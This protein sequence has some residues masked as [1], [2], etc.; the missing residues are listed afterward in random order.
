MKHLVFSGN[1][2]W[3]M[4]NFRG[5]LMRHFVEKGFKV[6]VTAPY[7]STFSPKLENLGCNFVDINIQAKGTNPFADF[8]LIV[9]Y[10]RLFKRLKPDMSITYTI[11]PNIYASIAARFLHIPFLPVTTGMGYVFLHNN[12]VCKIAKRL[13]RFAF[14]NAEKVWFLNG[15]DMSIFR[16]QKLIADDKIA[17]LH[18]EGIDTQRLAFEKLPSQEHECVFIL[19]GRILKDKGVVEYVEAARILKKKYTN[20]KFLLVGAIWKDNPAAISEM[21]LEE[22]R[23]EGAIDYLGTF[24]DIRIPLRKA[25]CVVLPS[26]R[27]GIPFTLMEG[28]SMGRPLIATDIPGCRDVVINEKTG[29]LCEVRSID[30]LVNAMEKVIGMSP[31]QREDMGRNGRKYMEQEFAIEHIIRQ[32]D[33]TVDKMC[34]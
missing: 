24:E 17:L 30:G 20:A 3:G 27:E 7:D 16:E 22:W 33:K 6:T 31:S 18:G 29:F 23:N 21:Q 9:R 11:K 12:V 15:D 19:V 25:D 10:I 1:T 13:Y 5:K 28:A 34:R 4:Y 8:L 32:Y 14:S 26:Y 2:A